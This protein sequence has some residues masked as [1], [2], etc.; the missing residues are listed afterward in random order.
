MTKHVTAK[1]TPKRIAP[2][3][4]PE[5]Q[6]NLVPVQFRFD[7]TLLAD[8]DQKVA[9]ANEGRVIKRNRTDVIRLL[10]HGWVQGTYDLDDAEK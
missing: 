8:V 2:R 10:L 4:P 6:G 1:K 7:P 9:K 3:T 5:G